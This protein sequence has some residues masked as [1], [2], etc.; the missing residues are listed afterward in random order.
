VSLACVGLAAAAVVS[1]GDRTLAVPVAPSG[2]V[3]T[4]PPGLAGLAGA[5]PALVPGSA[6]TSEV[7]LTGSTSRGLTGVV[8]EVEPS[9]WSPRPPSG[10][11]P[12]LSVAV[13][14]CSGAWEPAAAVPGA[15]VCRGIV[16]EVASGVVGRVGGELPLAGLAGLAGFG[17]V[18][19]AHLQ[20]ALEVP[21][22]TP[23]D[24]RPTAVHLAFAAPSGVA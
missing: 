22:G 4:T 18:D 14:A 15:V 19:A 20:V 13:R 23:G 9:G 6:V 17:R 16:R 10:S 12:T 5:H 11:A 1:L 21:A 24:A 8:L 7:D 2:L 3:A